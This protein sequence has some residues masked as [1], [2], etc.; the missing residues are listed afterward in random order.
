MSQTEIS[1]AAIVH[2][3]ITPTE[4]IQRGGGCSQLHY[5][6]RDHTK[7][8]VAQRLIQHDGGCSQ[9]HYSTRDH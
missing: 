9:L 5:F 1:V 4:I 7:L 3:Y 6:T 2:N 8:S